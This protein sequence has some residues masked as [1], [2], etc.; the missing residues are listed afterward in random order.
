MP[1]F[2]KWNR[3]LHYYTGLFLL[4]FLWLFSLTGLLLNHPQWKFAEFWPTRA[5]STFERQINAPPPGDDLTQARDIMRQLGLRGEIEWT[6]T[7]SGM[8]RLDF[9][10]SR[11]GHSFEVGTDLAANRAA[12]HRIDLNAW[13]V[14]RLLHTFTGVRAQDTRNHRDWIMTTIWAFSMDAVALG[15]ILMVFGS[16]YMWWI[17]PQKRRRGLVAAGLG[18][19]GCGYFVFALRWLF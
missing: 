11:P 14:T 3:K 13:G 1:S 6:K 10:V 2:T 17:Q 15:S 19:A 16:L 5:Q 8:A 7:R 12:V 18:V 9:R 4:L